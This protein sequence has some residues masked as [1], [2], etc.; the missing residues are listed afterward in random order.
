[1]LDLQPENTFALLVAVSQYPPNSGFAN[2]PNA[3]VSL[4][5]LKT[6]LIDASIL[7][8]PQANITAL[9]NPSMTTFGK[10]LRTVCRN[11]ANEASKNLLVYYVGHGA[12]GGDDYQL[13]LTSSESERDALEYGA[14]SIERF[15]TELKEC[16]A[17]KKV[18]ILD[19]CHSGAIVGDLNTY[20]DGFRA[21]VK[22]LELEENKG[23]FIMT[24]ADEYSPAKYDP[25]N[26]GIPT[27]F[28]QDLVAIM[29]QGL[30]GTQQLQCITTHELFKEMAHRAHKKRE[31]GFDKYPMPI[32]LSKEQ[33]GDIRF[34]L[35][36]QMTHSLPNQVPTKP[37][38]EKAGKPPTNVTNTQARRAKMTMIKEEI[39]VL[40]DRDYYQATKELAKIIT[41]G[42]EGYGLLMDYQKELLSKP[43]NF[44]KE[45]FRQKL[46]MFVDMYL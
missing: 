11:T 15:K 4:D 42:R 23:V 9:L 35:N 8:L 29:Q 10:A 25:N 41:E 38:E 18:V 5:K 32:T 6:A 14:V 44:Q 45:E 33:G 26:Q 13:Y 16:R 1:M 20:E 31:A 21:Q 36:K 19:C 2:I 24:A 34:C 30:A 27:Y 17:S 43:A 39:M 22:K 46:K 40:I 12:V 3:E 37:K 7:G 28:T